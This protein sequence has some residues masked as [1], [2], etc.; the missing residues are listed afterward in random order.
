MLY[1]GNR[2]VV[3]SNLTP[4]LPEIRHLGCRASN[5][6]PTTCPQDVFAL[7]VEKLSTASCLQLTCYKVNC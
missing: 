6:V 4:P 2:T 1:K 3:Q 7:L 5:A